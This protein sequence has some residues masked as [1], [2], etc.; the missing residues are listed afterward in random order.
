MSRKSLTLIVGM[1]LALVFI[2][3]QTLILTS[4]SNNQRNEEKLQELELGLEVSQEETLVEGQILPEE[5]T[6]EE[7]PED[8]DNEE[9]Q[10]IEMEESNN[11][12]EPEASYKA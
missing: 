2:T 3:T 5:S 6:L 4:F 12:S 1:S 9:N 11:K 8:D 7:Q 10:P